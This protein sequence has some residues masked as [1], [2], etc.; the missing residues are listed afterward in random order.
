MKEK[1]TRWKDIKE[2]KEEELRARREREVGKEKKDLELKRMK[3]REDRAK[4][5]E[6]RER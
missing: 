6:V 2:G 4:R 5:K 1:E 3:G